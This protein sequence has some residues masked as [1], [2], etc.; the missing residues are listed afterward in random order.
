[1]AAGLPVVGTRETFSAIRAKHGMNA[2]V[3]T[4]AELAGLATSV[5]DDAERLHLGGF[6]QPLCGSVQVVGSEE[7]CQPT[8]GAHL[9]VTDRA[10]R[11][12]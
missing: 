6:D 8:R 12:G 9:G 7:C 10:R 4:M 1:M 5:M 3:G 11:S 2:L